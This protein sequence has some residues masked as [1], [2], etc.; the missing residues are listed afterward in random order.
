MLNVLQQLISDC[1]RDYSDV[2][3]VLDA[4]RGDIGA[5][6]EAYAIEAFE[7][8]KADAV[9]VNP[10]MGKDT[11]EPFT[12]YK[13]RGVFLLCRTSNPAADVTQ[14]IRLEGG[15]TYYNYLAE[16][17]TTQ[18]NEN[19]N[20]GFV[21]GATAVDELSDIRI[22]FPKTWFLVPGVGF[23][24][25]SVSDVME[26]GTMGDGHG[27]LINSA[28]GI[29]YASQGEDYAEAAGKKAAEIQSQMAGYFRN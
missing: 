19:N 25:G 9:T 20:V 16:V 26:K 4:K 5:S 6:A 24:G 13:D 1:H 3:V 17:A 7:R 23:Q 28:R 14:N 29:I 11:V 21:V 10:Y 12:N 8:Y 27:A 18:W 2:Q 15:A 22:R